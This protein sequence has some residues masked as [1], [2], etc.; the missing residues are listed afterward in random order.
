MGRAE[1]LM[2]RIKGLIGNREQ[3]RNMGIVA[4]IDHG[5]TTLSDN[6]LSNAGLISS[7]MAGKQLAL[8]FH[9]DEQ[10]RGIT[11]NAA[12][13]SMVHEYEGTEYPL[14]KLEIS[15]ASHPFFTGQERFVDA[16]GRVERFQKKFGG[17]YFKKPVKKQH[18]KRK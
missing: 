2:E 13:V 7:E 15:S 16:L 6:L 9:E 18:A 10:A 4:H 12:N 3:I 1:K 5:K 17:E 11:I 14:V 8:D